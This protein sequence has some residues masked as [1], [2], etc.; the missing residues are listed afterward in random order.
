M[1]RFCKHGDELSDAIRRGEVLD[2]YREKKELLKKEFSL[3]GGGD[4][5]YVEDILNLLH[6]F[7]RYSHYLSFQAPAFNIPQVL[8][9]KI[10]QTS[11]LFNYIQL[12][13]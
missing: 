7:W 2:Y 5:I 1:A 3:W 8:S 9:S 10:L 13:R 4:V 12:S 6:I 11:Y